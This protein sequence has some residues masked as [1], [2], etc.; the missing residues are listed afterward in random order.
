MEI[1]HKFEDQESG[2]RFRVYDHRSEP[3]PSSSSILGKWKWGDG[4]LEIWQKKVGKVIANKVCTLACAKG[5]Y[6]HDVME[7]YL[8][9][10]PVQVKTEF[11]KLYDETCRWVDK[12]KIIEV[13]GTEVDVYHPDY[14]Y[15]GR[16]DAIV[17]R[18]KGIY[19]WDWKTGDMRSW[20]KEKKC[21]GAYDARKFVK[22]G[23]QL[24]SYAYAYKAL[25][26]CK[27]KIFLTV[28]NPCM[29]T[30]KFETAVTYVHKDYLMKGFLCKLE[31]WKHENFNMLRDGW[32]L[33]GCT[34]LF[35][36]DIKLIL[37]DFYKDFITKEAKNV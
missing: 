22:A 16:I 32:N 36:W 29:K 37:K 19:I 6:F 14:L 15:S 3:H 25:T 4:G 2:F 30:Q 5:T 10:T 7:N 9:G 21:P 18:E 28:I 17:R 1:I 8:N 27:D 33:K 20:N 12:Q 34:K 13:I 35:K 26:G 11:L 24:A 31:A 23:E